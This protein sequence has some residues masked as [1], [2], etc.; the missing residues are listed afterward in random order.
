[1]LL[2]VGHRVDQG[3]L[4]PLGVIQQQYLQPCLI[5]VHEPNQ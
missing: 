5:C 1:M 3:N 4:L 2:I